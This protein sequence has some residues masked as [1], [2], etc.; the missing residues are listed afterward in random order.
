[1]GNGAKLLLMIFVGILLIEIG[2]TGR[3]GSILA[4]VIAPEYL[5]AGT[6]PTTGIP[7][8]PGGPGVPLPG[9]WQQGG[10]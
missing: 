1:M 8:A 4:A 7:P 3:L 9:P 10:G 6:P 5:V 2:L